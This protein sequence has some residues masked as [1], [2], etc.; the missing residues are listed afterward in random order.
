MLVLIYFYATSA[1]E[2]S[3]DGLTLAE[4]YKHDNSLH[5]LMQPLVDAVSNISSRNN[6]GLNVQ[7]IDCDAC[8][9]DGIERFP[10]FKLFRDNKLV[11]SFF[12]YK[13]YDKLVKFLSL[14]EKLFHRSPGESSGEIVELEERDFYSGF[15]GPWLILFYYDKSNHDELLKQLHD[16]FRGRIKLGKIKHT[17]SGYLMSRFHVRA[18]PMVYALY[19]GLTVPFLDDLNI[20][21]L[22]KFTNRLLEPTFKT[23]SYQE[24]LSLSQDKYNLEPIYVVLTRDQTKANEMFFRY[25]HSFKFKIRLYKS[26][27]S[28]LFEHAQVFP[29]AS[30]DK[31]VVYKNGSYFAYDGDMGDEN[32][33]VEWIFHTHFPNVTRI[34]N[35]SFHS[36]FNGIKPVFLLLTEDDNLLEQF[37]YFSN[38]VHLGKPY[39]HILFSSIN[40]NEYM[41]FTASLLPKIEVPSFV[42]YNPMDKKFYY[43]KASLTRENFQQTA[44]NTLKLFESGSLKPYSKESHINLYIGIV[45]GI[46]IVLGILIMK[47]KQ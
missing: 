32:S 46:L 25:A 13:S 23:I 7:R 29:T 31:L 10:T 18:Y 47:Y 21:N 33:V 27:D 5:Q 36:I 9:C 22:I 42:V 20:T 28:V 16:V 14:D 2:V 34:S 37:E 41:L 43:K 15:D 19:N 17:Q 35:A 3:K 38:N 44:E 39:L 40:L 12:G 6:L 24:L 45:I 26:T 30:E 11:D 4:F 8:G 1:C